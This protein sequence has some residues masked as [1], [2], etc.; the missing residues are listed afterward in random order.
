MKKRVLILLVLGLF[1]SITI[2]CSAAESLSN[3][4]DASSAKPWVRAASNLVYSQPRSLSYGY[5][6]LK[7]DVLTPA[8]IKGPKPT[9]VFVTGGGFMFA[10]KD[11]FIQQRLA[12]A[13]AGYVVFS[14]EYRVAPQSTFPAAVEDVKSAIRYVRANAEKFEVD[15][16]RI[17]VMGQS[18]GGYLAAMA[19]TTNGTKQFDKGDY[20]DQRSDVQA[21]VDLFG[22]SDLTQASAGFSSDAKKR[23]ES[24]AAP[25]ALFVNGSTLIG[26]GG[27]V[28]DTPEKTS[29]A[30]PIHYISEATPPF[31]LMHGD[32][33][34]TVSPKGTELLHEALISK[35][36]DSTRYIVKGAVHNGQAWSQDNVMKIVLGF[37]DKNLKAKK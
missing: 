11:S 20:L 19:G 9:V 5:T 10:I 24:S 12:L 37:L 36:I 29:A 26:P 17:A 14:I 18:A 23:A 32:K 2:T 21:V 31:L 8:S 4:I 3:E 25:E 28:T 22:L 35:G 13:E 1:M 6:P 33:D 30:N 34:K 27:S 15:T 7:M 16:D